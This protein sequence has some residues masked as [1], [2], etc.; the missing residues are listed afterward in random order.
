M[1]VCTYKEFVIVTEAPQCNRKTAAG[2]DTQIIIY[3][4]GNV[5]KSKNTILAIAKEAVSPSGRFPSCIR[6]SS[7]NSET[8]DSDVFMRG[9]YKRQQ[10]WMEYA[11]IE[12]VVVCHGFHDNSRVE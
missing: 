4:T 7:R 3:K 2:Q 5:Q 1:Y 12:A 11:L 8:A 10:Q 6:T 9:L